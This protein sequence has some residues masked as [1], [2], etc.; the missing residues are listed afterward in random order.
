MSID[1]AALQG[2]IE[3]FRQDNGRLPRRLEELVLSHYTSQLPT[4]P[5]G[6][7]Y[8][9]DPRAGTVSSSAGRVLANP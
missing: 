7:G 4:D 8:A 5:Y 9:Y 3:R 2:L 6:R 1:I